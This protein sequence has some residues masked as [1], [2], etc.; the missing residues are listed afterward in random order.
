MNVELEI[1]CQ[2]CSAEELYA[3]LQA[4]SAVKL[5]GVELTLAAE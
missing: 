2:D 5:E 4:D 1:I 3:T